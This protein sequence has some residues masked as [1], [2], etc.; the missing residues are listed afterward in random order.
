[1]KN[2]KTFL[3]TLY[4]QFYEWMEK[5]IDLDVKELKQMFDL[6]LK[7]DRRFIRY[8]SESIE[9]DIFEI[10]KT[11]KNLS[12]EEVKQVYNFISCCLDVYVYDCIKLKVPNSNLDLLYYR[13]TLAHYYIKNVLDGTIDLEMFAS[14]KK[15][16]YQV[17][18]I[19]GS[20][21]KAKDRKQ[22]S[23]ITD[24]IK[25]KTTELFKRFKLDYSLP[26]CTI[27]NK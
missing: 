8:L 25:S 14:F 21:Y 11:I 23:V 2:I 9:N 22:A 17:G 13:S 20:F 4:V 1:M 3:N 6:L 19:I 24:M 18:V 10:E 27:C 15:E 16:F 12:E 5:D 26:L 7:H